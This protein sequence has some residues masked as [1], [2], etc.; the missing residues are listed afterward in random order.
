MMVENNDCANPGNLNNDA[1][2]VVRLYF[3]HSFI[4]LSNAR[5]IHA[6][7]KQYAVFV[8]DIVEI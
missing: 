3:I 7:T 6:V 5:V 1:Y 2:N 8:A 4:H